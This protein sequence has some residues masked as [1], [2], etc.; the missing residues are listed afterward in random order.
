V[1]FLRSFLDKQKGAKNSLM[2]DRKLYKIAI[3]PMGFAVVLSNGSSPEIVL[4][5]YRQLLERS[6]FA[7]PSG[8]AK[9]E[10]EITS[11]FYTYVLL[12]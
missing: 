5:I 4:A 3:L 8:Q 1:S 6:P 2:L 9:V 7:P 11:Q 10:K 12:P